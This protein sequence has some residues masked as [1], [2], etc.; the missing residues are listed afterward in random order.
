MEMQGCDGSSAG[1]PPAY[2]RPARTGNAARLFRNGVRIGS[3]RRFSFASRARQSRENVSL[4]SSSFS[5]VVQLGNFPLA[6]RSA[7]ALMLRFI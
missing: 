1:I 5:P 7:P 6:R 4:R 2:R 3:S